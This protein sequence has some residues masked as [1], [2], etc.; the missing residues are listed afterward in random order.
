MYVNSD[1]KHKRN[2]RANDFRSNAN[3]PN[4]STHIHDN[5]D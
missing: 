2:K 3:V 5:F 1:P 4:V